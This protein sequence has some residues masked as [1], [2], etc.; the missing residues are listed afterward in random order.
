MQYIQRLSI[1]VGSFSVVYIAGSVIEPFADK[2]GPL[3]FLIVIMDVAAIIYLSIKYAAI[4][5]ILAFFLFTIAALFY[6]INDYSKQ[7]KKR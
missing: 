7:E 1:I 2:M 6:K 4:T 5:Y 3:S